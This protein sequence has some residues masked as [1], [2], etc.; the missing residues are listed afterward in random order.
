MLN[1]R[2]LRIK[3]LQALYAFEQSKSTDIAKA[4][5][6]L[7]EHIQKMYDMYLYL[8]LIMLEIRSIFMKTN[9]EQVTFLLMRI[10]TEL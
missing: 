6:R 4:E 10:I 2:H 8:M 1:R 3:I 7:F 5:E 9:M